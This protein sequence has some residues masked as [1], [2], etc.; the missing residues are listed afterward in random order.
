MTLARPEAKESC[1]SWAGTHLR[2]LAGDAVSGGSA[3]PL[4]Q[5]D[6][7]CSWGTPD[8]PGPC[9]KGP[10]SSPQNSGALCTQL[11]FPA[12]QLVPILSTGSAQWERAALASSRR[13]SHWDP[14]PPSPES[15][16]PRVAPVQTLSLCPSW[17]TC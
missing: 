8:P 10:D 1:R 17:W 13:V 9:A 12:I 2:P 14:P 3:R 16:G 6:A 5:L 7:S 4:S 15:A 11:T